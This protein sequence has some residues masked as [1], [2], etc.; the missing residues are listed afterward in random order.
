MKMTS[1]I[2]TKCFFSILFPFYLFKT[3]NYNFIYFTTEMY[4]SNTVSNDKCFTLLNFFFFLSN[5]NEF[6]LTISIRNFSVAKL[7]FTTFSMCFESQCKENDW[8]ND[9]KE[10]NSKRSASR[11]EMLK[12]WYSHRLKS[13][14]SWIELKW[15]DER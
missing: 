13:L 1:V 9:Q 8:R 14:K 7:F 4:G 6:K 5:L 2:N 12:V 10:S 15:Q 3:L 11:F